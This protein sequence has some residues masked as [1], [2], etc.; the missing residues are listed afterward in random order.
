MLKGWSSYGRSER[1]RQ[2]YLK[3]GKKRE[4]IEEKEGN[5]F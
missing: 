2:N 4:K 5:L 1:R 3:W